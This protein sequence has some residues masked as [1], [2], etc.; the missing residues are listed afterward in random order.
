MFYKHFLCGIYLLYSSVASSLWRLAII[1]AIIMLD[2]PPT[3]SGRYEHPN[4][5]KFP[6]SRTH[7][8]FLEIPDS[9]SFLSLSVVLYTT[10]RIIWPRYSN[11][12][13]SVNFPNSLSYFNRTSSLVSFCPWDVLM[14]YYNK[15]LQNTTCEPNLT[16]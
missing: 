12:L 16:S 2:T 5:F 14:V 10:P 4:H 1:M 8:F 9:R 6:Y 15:S 7:I 3:K 13:A 11:F